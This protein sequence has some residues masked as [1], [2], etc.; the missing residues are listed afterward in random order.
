[1]GKYFT[2]SLICLA[3]ATLTSNLVGCSGKTIS[4]DSPAEEQY[5]EGER[6]F[7]KE[8]F[9]EAVERYRIIRSRYPHSKFAALS[10]LRIGDAHFS[11]EA[12]GEAAG[13]YRSFRELYPKHE[14]AGYAL[15]RIGEANYNMLPSTIDRDLEP[16]LAAIDAYKEY[17][18]LYPNNAESSDA[19]KKSAE[20][21][22]KLAAKEDYIGNFYF[23]REHFLSAAT[24]YANL[25]DQYPNRGFD[26]KALYRLAVSYEKI[27]EPAKAEEAI[28]KLRDK[29]SGSEY[30]KLS[31]IVWNKVQEE[32]TKQ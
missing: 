3:L 13:A 21:Q 30:E 22:T 4:N 17:Q 28:S 6:L 2:L 5:T 27:G 18:K 24:R 7:K 31:R 19:A 29:F 1:M 14:Q 11:E 25:L 8:R 10:S 16:A 20:L 12:W 32:K 26:E 23:I 9:L 15:F